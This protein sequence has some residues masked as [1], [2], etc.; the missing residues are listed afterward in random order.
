MDISGKHIVFL[1]DNYFEQ[2]E[3]EEPLSA[4]R[5]AGGEVSVISTTAGEVQGMNHAEMGDKF[6]VDMTIN[7]ASSDDY[8]CLVLPGGV[9]NADKLRMNGS[10]QKWV[11]DFINSPRPI[12]VICH[13]P[14]VL[15]SA[16][17]IEGRRLTSY[18]TI[19][20][21]I[22]NAGAE[23]VDAEVVIDANLITSRSPDDIPKFNEAIINMLSKKVA[24][25][26]AS[27]EDMP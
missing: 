4:L 10:A 22:R 26:S 14:W 18:Y 7:R 16:D 15:V 5:D 12:A 20:D 11:A 9:I 19:Q 6:P 17:C 25:A 8:D 23:W 1:L 24:V 27:V 13:A 2:A 21:D 3:L